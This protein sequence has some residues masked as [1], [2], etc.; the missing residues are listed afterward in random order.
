MIQARSHTIGYFTLIVLVLS[1]SVPAHIGHG[2]AD[3]MQFAL[4]DVAAAISVVAIAQVIMFR[5][6]V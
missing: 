4:F 5:R 3:L 2:V 6:G 1:L